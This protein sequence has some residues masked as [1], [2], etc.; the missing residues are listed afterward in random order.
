[1]KIIDS[2]KINTVCNLSILE[3]SVKNFFSWINP[4]HIQGEYGIHFDFVFEKVFDKQRT[5]YITPSDLRVVLHCM[6]ESLTED[7]SKKPIFQ[8]FFF[9]YLFLEKTFIFFSVDEMIS[10]VDLDGDGRIDFDGQF[11]QISTKK[12]DKNV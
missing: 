8:I 7:E 10:E 11:I 5:G 2:E 6:G 1:L 9:L 12:I 4:Y 3:L